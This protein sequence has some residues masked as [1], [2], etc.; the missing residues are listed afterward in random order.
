MSRVA[1]IWRAAF[2]STGWFGLALQYWLLTATGHSLAD[3]PARTLNYFSYFT[4]LTNLLVAL[5]L[6]LPVVAPASRAG[7][8]ALQ[9][10]VRA[11]ATMYLV[12]VGLGYH[13]LL[14][15][16]STLQGLAAFGNIIVHYVMPVAILL[17]WLLFTP[18]GGLRWTDPF[19]WLRYPLIYFAWTVIHGYAAGWWP[20]WFLNLPQLGPVRSALAVA[21][22]LIALLIAGFAFVAI[23]RTLTRRDRTPAPA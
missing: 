4:I 11:R 12:V 10:S 18:R 1:L 23:D 6:T 7:R 3:I 15:A 8:W 13:L 17:D 2:A 16:S 9:P 22:L 14:S 19:R 5:I 20:Y 21:A